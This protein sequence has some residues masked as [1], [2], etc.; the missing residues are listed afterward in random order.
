M[1]K[2]LYIEISGECI[3]KCPSCFTMSQKYYDINILQSILTDA[4]DSGF[5]WVGLCGKDVF[6]H[7][8]CNE[9]LNVVLNIGFNVRVYTGLLSNKIEPKNFQNFNSKL[10]ITFIVWGMPN[11]HDLHCGID[12]AFDDSCQKL[13]SW[14]LAGARVAAKYFPQEKYADQIVGVKRI[15]DELGIPLFICVWP[16]PLQSQ[17]SQKGLKPLSVKMAINILKYQNQFYKYR[18]DTQKSPCKAG[19][20]RVFISS[21]FQLKACSIAE[22][23]IADLKKQKFIDVWNQDSYWGK[24]RSIKFKDLQI[25]TNC[26]YQEFCHVCPTSYIERNIN[27]CSPEKLE[28]AKSM[29]EYNSL[30]TKGD[31]SYENVL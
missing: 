15:F 11:V 23:P 3:G 14:K 1:L 20:K 21:D 5:N 25:C 6:Q 12:G 28:W 30:F 19:L 2:K 13:L 7:N 16:M 8:Q 22:K 31:Q 10:D 18:Y 27:I 9:L 17:K 4:Y 24:W 26:Q 29:Y